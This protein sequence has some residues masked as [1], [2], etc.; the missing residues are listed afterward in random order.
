[1]IAWLLIT[2]LISGGGTGGAPPAGPVP[3]F[4]VRQR[5]KGNR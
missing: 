1:M 5:R 3:E 2:R 4:I